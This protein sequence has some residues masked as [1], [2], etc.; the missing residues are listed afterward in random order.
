MKEKYLPNKK[1]YNFST[2]C[3]CG[4]V[5]DE[6]TIDGQVLYTGQ[7]RNGLGCSKRP[8]CTC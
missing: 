2:N 4:V 7:N 6:K 3:T 5:V 1:Y 8:H